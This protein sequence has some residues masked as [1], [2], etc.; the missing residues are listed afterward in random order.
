MNVRGVFIGLIVCVACTGSAALGADPLL[1]T[2][3]KLTQNVEGVFTASNARYE[4][5]GKCY[6]GSSFTTWSV[7]ALYENDRYTES[8]SVGN[9]V[10]AQVGIIYSISRMPCVEDPWLTHTKCEA[11][12][13]R[14]QTEPGQTLSLWLEAHF[15][16]R[17]N[18]Y[19]AFSA[20]FNYDRAALLAKRDA[21]L[22]AGAAA[23]QQQNK[24]LN[25]A[26]Q[27]SPARVT[28]TILSP[29]TNA[30]F[31]SQTSIPIKIVPPQGMA[32]TG[33]LVRVELR[34]AQGQWM[35]VTNLP[36]G[37]AEA[38]SPS[39][40]LGWGAPGPGRGANMIAGPGTY[41]VSAQ[42]SSPRQTGWSQPV[43]FVVTAPKKAI[44]RAPKMFGP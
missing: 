26:V 34:N 37:A 42:V 4:L 38:H 10:G 35:L 8:L 31:L 22:N 16:P 11:E 9:G 2:S 43:E 5:H 14:Q 36:V 1:Q 39:G 6:I 28:P 33:Y 12:I 41:R 24:R 30:L 29:A 27:P 15:Y 23:L 40:Y 32:V 3:C 7:T 19:N 17:H 13:K 25:Q 18:Q 21:D 44:Q 20:T